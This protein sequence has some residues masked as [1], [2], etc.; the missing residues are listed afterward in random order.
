MIT[1]IFLLVFFS[2]MQAN[3]PDRSTPEPPWQSGAA[4]SRQKK[5]GES[6]NYPFQPRLH[7][8][9]IRSAYNLH[10][11]HNLADFPGK[12]SAR[13][14]DYFFAGNA[15]YEFRLTRIQII[16]THWPG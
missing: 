9:T 6:D 7:A 12:F 1:S 16:S 5:P 4:D 11:T 15:E 14:H 2:M 13:S 8:P 10:V 3:S